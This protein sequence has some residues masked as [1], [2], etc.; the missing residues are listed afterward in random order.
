[1]RPTLFALFVGIV[2][3]SACTAAP[4]TQQN[5]SNVSGANVSNVSGVSKPSAEAGVLIKPTSEST[6]AAKVADWLKNL[7]V[8]PSEHFG[9]MDVPS[10]QNLAGDVS[11]LRS[12]VLQKGTAGLYADSALLQK[13]L[14]TLEEKF[15]DDYRFTA[16]A[17]MRYVRSEPGPFV[18]NLI[19][20]EK[21]KGYRWEFADL[22]VKMARKYGLEPI[23]A[24]RQ[25]SAW[26]TSKCGSKAS[27]MTAKVVEEGSFWYLGGYFGPVCDL[28]D[29]SRWLEAMVERYDGDGKD[30]MPGLNGQPVKLWEIFNEVQGPDGG[31]KGKGSKYAE[32][33]KRSS[34]IIKKHCPSCIVTNDGAF[35]VT[36]GDPGINIKGW[37]KDAFGA[38][39]GSAIDALNWHWNVERNGVQSDS[40]YRE[41]LDGFND[42][43]RQ[44]GVSKPMWI[45]EIGTFAGASSSTGGGV[46]YGGEQGGQQSSAP[47]GGQPQGGQ[48]PSGQQLGQPPSGGG[49]GRCG[50]GTCDS[51][52][53]S[54]GLCPM[55]CGGSGNIRGPQPGPTQQSSQQPPTQIQ[56][57][58]TTQSE[59]EQASWYVRRYALGFAKGVTLFTP[60]TMGVPTEKGFGGVGT[61]SL[62]YRESLGSQVGARFLFY[63]HKL[64]VAKI[65]KFTSAEELAEGQYRF[66]NAGKTVYILWKT[67]SSLSSQIS[68]R[69]KVT[70]LYGNEKTVEAAQ[71][72]LTNTPV[73]AEPV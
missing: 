20:P 16:A 70:D 57:G 40:K 26:D 54:S 30:D 32:V 71:L 65:G 4:G 51:I 62:V 48:Q 67:P 42:L 46:F 27:G 17:G 63:V 23:I 6:T 47:T 21:G 72:T 43:M 73:F 2:L 69:L 24:V 44:A 64:L 59:E 29:Y 58:G 45:T 7:A 49:G 8:E 10:Y 55:D 18:W 50:D 53:Q 56:T 35:D 15:D 39:M 12:T 36:L 11:G 13:A 52:E 19:E 1:M 3:I 61:G 68:G 25:Y 37:F 28:D 38:G 31:Y 14:K 41:A 9:G 33:A 22:H 60:D 5:V 66:A 34:E